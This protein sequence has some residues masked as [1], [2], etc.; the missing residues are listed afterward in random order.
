M[1]QQT[2]FY[3]FDKP[4]DQKTNYFWTIIFYSTVPG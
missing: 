2:V 3:F 4:A 1:I